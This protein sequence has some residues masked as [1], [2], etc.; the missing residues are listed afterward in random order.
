MK[1]NFTVYQADW[2]KVI[3][4][5]AGR[6][7]PSFGDARFPSEFVAVARVECEELGETFQLTNSID[8]Y[9]WRN[10]GVE[11]LGTAEGYRS[12]SVGDVVV[13]D[14]TGEAFAV[15]GCGFSSLGK[16]DEIGDA[17]P[18]GVPF[19][20]REILWIGGPDKGTF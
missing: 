6:R 15:R 3:N 17:A 13:D 19:S 2:E 20:L 8:D 5:S 4:G 1:K 14:A 10:A 12:T 18:M 16:A 9:W 7:S 11:K